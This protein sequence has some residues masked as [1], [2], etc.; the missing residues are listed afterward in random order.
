M[1]MASAVMAVEDF[2]TIRSISVVAYDAD[3]NVV[4]YE[5]NAYQR[6]SIASLTKIMTILYTCELVQEEKISLSDVVTAS[7]NAASRGGTQIRLRG[8]DQFTL[9][10][11]LYATALASANDGAVAIAE[12]VGGSEQEFARLMTARAH[13][14][15]IIN[16]NFVDSTGLLSIYSGNYSTAL[17]LARLSTIAMQN[18]L[19]QRFVST[20]EYFLTPQDRIIRNTNPLLHAVE[21]MEGI[22]TGATTPAGHTLITSTTRNERRLIV[23]VLG[24]PSR[25]Q[26]NQE[27][28]RIVEY[29]FNRLTTVVPAGEVVREVSVKDAVLHLVDAVS[30]KDVSLFLFDSDLESIERKA[31]VGELRAPVEKGETIGEL[32]I[33][34]DDKELGRFELVANQSTGLASIIRRFWNRLVSFLGFTL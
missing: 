16:T 9:E 1:Y 23:V 15:G 5:K 32:I 27:A 4:L 22:K 8:G 14:L 20:K 10:E 18:D 30:A 13:Q 11:L 19:F 34:R 24:A 33:L 7:S 31:E 25:E 21:G 6:R 12:F 28:E 3:L 2:P 17:D 26:R 29:A